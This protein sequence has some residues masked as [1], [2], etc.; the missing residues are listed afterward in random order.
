MPDNQ[1]KT[2]APPTPAQLKTDTPATQATRPREARWRLRYFIARMDEGE[3]PTVAASLSFTTMLQIVPAMALLLAVLTAFPAF[4]SV[5][6]TVQQFLLRNLVPDTGL[7]NERAVRA[8]VPRCRRPAQ[9]LGVIGLT[10]TTILTLLTIEASFN[11]IF[12]VIRHRPLR[13]RLLVL[14]AVITVGPKLLGLSF[15][16]AQYFGTTGAWLN[17]GAPPTFSV[18]LGVVA[19]VVVTWLALTF[20][21]SVVP[22]RRVSLPDAMVARRWPRSCWRCCATA[23]PAAS[24]LPGAAPP[25]TRAPT[26]RARYAARRCRRRQ[27]LLRREPSDAPLRPLLRYRTGRA[28]RRLL[29]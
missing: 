10:V 28:R 4:Q 14:W 12:K 13:M 23:S 27:R 22:N 16:L 24:R 11:T 17:A 26:D 15:T 18:F 5:R 21:Y 3:V 9:G 1:L 7:Q 20:I 19:P 25:A 6:M 8:A 2:D 29:R